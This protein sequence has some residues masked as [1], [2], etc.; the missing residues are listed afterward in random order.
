VILVLGSIYGSIKSI[1]FPS[2]IPR[3]ITTYS[4]LDIIVTIA[5]SYIADFYYRVSS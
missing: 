1:L 5:R 4:I 3:T 2:P